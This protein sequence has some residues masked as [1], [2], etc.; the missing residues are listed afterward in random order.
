MASTYPNVVPIRM[1]MIWRVIDYVIW[2]KTSHVFHMATSY[3][4]RQLIKNLSGDWCGELMITWVDRKLVMSLIWRVIDYVSSSKTSHVFDLTSYRWRQLIKNSSCD[5][6]GE[7]SITEID[8]KL[9][10]Y[11]MWR[12]I[13]YDNWLLVMWLI[14]WVIN[15]GNWS[16]SRHVVDMASYW[17]RDLI[18]NLSYIWCGELSITWVHRNLVIYLMWRVIKYDN[19]SKTRHVIDMVSCR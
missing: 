15:N 3:W 18:K 4:L 1:W 7:L 16:K 2:S 8:R 14:W 19:W 6:Y 9:V 17:L 5:W 10:I 13:K 12:V 11:L